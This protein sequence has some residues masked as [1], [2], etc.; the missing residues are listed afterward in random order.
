MNNNNR[1]NVHQYIHSNSTISYNQSYH[2]VQYSEPVNQTNVASDQEAETARRQND[3]LTA[4]NNPSCLR[5]SS[6]I[7]VCLMCVGLALIITFVVSTKLYLIGLVS[8]GSI[9]LCYSFIFGIILLVRCCSIGS[10]RYFMCPCFMN[11]LEIDQL[12]QKCQIKHDQIYGTTAV[13]QTDN[14]VLEATKISV[15]LEVRTQY[16]QQNMQ[17][18]ELV[19]SAVM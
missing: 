2:P 15:K 16:Q 14:L 17:A 6:W 12:K 7:L 13:V 11:Q 10:I 4:F 19:F 1:S 5:K 18:K 8:V 3:P 9:I